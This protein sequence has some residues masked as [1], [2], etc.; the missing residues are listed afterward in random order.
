MAR[1]LHGPATLHIGPA[2]KCLAGLGL[3]ASYFSN[4][5]SRVQLV[6]AAHAQAFAHDV[7]LQRL[8]PRLA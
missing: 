3:R 5:A 2:P 6:C 1:H 8:A 4:Q 7:V